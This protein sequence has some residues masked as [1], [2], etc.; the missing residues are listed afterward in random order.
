M[1]PAQRKNSLLAR[2]LKISHL[3][4]LSALDA[5]L[6]LSTA[7]SEIG[8]SQPAASRLVTEIEGIVGQRVHERSGR[9][10]ELTQMGLALA[11]RARRVLLELDDTDRDLAEIAAGNVGHVR[12]GTVVGA[13]LHRILPAVQAERRAHPGVTFEV[14]VAASDALCS[15]LLEGQLDFALGRLPERHLDRDLSYAALEAEPADLVVRRGHPVL[16]DCRINTILDLDWIMPPAESLLTRSILLRLQALGLPRPRMPIATGSF[17]VTLALMMRSDSL[18]VVPRSVAEQF[19]TEGQPLQ[20]LPLALGFEVEP[21]GMI[22]RRGVSLTQAA[23]R[24]ADLV[25]LG[26]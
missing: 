6:P 4:L 12:V 17:M 13:A 15:Q 26:A 23:R 19:A 5:G 10:I 9:G 25:Q 24:L 22:A 3:R 1:I 16:A 11:R 2:G 14:V 7:A 8:I 18:A 20:M 21:F